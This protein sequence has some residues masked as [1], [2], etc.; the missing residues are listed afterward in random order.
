MTNRISIHARTDYP[1]D[2]GKYPGAL[3]SMGLHAFAAYVDKVGQSEKQVRAF[4]EMTEKIPRLIPQLVNEAIPKWIR[5]T[6]P[7]ADNKKLALE[8]V[9]RFFQRLLA[10]E[11]NDYKEVLGNFMADL[12]TLKKL[13]PQ[14]LAMADSRGEY[15]S[16]PVYYRI[17]SALSCAGGR[18]RLSSPFRAGKP[19]PVSS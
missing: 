11:N 8:E 12:T 10:E 15:G 5:D 6:T 16:P 9:S 1:I 2:K 18:A 17:C 14:S 19:S 13:N 7:D 4:D 3:H